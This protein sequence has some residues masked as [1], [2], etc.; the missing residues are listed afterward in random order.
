[1]LLG[2]EM[3]LVGPPAVGVKLRD[4]KRRQQLL[5]LQEDVVLS[6][7]KHIRQNLPRM[8]INGVPQPARVR[9]AAHV[10]PHFVEFGGEPPPAI[11]FLGATNLYGDVLGLHALQYCMVYL[12]EVRFLFFSSVMTVLVLICKTRAVSRMPL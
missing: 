12:V 7:A 6:P 5:E 11:Q 1:M 3:S 9:F 2:I 4:A 10:T 8:L